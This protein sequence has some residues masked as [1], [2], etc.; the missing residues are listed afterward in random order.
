MTITG[1]RTLE[2]V[3]AGRYFSHTVGFEQKITDSLADEPDPIDKPTLSIR[4][5]GPLDKDKQ[6]KAR[7]PDQIKDWSEKGSTIG[8]II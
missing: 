7:K 4:K 8:Q 5:L 6:G 2:D 3:D 1:D